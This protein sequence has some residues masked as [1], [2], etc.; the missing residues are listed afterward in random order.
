MKMKSAVTLVLVVLFVVTSAAVL[1]PMTVYTAPPTGVPTLDAHFCKATLHGTWTGKTRTC[2]IRTLV[3]D[4]SIGNFAIPSKT[5]LAIGAGGTEISFLT[6]NSGVTI[7]NY[8]VIDSGTMNNNV[9]GTIINYGT[10]NN[11]CFG[12]VQDYGTWVNYGSFC[13]CNQ[14]C[15]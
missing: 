15:V 6:I 13:D 7:T 1:A 8:G 9:G 10:I 5:T 4:S 2:T 14:A 11:K 12:T 3:V